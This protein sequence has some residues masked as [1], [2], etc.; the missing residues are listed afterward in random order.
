[1]RRTKT[2]SMCVELDRGRASWTEHAQYEDDSA[3]FQWV[4]CEHDI[5]LFA[6]EER[7]SHIWM[8]KAFHLHIRIRRYSSCC[9]CA[10]VLVGKLYRCVSRVFDW[11]FSCFHT[12]PWKWHPKKS[13]P[14]FIFSVFRML[15]PSSV[16]CLHTVTQKYTHTIHLWEEKFPFWNQTIKELCE[17]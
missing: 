13:F 3:E 7:K 6:F 5:D 8:W 10:C 4:T 11:D 9:L 12:F 15:S 2:K 1:L 16:I 14:I 17:L